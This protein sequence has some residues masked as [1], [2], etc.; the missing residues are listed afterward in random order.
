MARKPKDVYSR[1]TE[2]KVQIKEAEDRLQTLNEELKAL[3]KER[4]DLEMKQMFEAARE[5]NVDVQQVINIIEKM[6]K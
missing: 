3:N 2:Q 4:D 6:S 5:R 1:I